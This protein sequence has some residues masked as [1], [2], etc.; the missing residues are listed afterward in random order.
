MQKY[1][2]WCNNNW[3]SSKF[4]YVNVKFENMKK[5]PL[6]QAN[7]GQIWL[8]LTEK[9]RQKFSFQPKLTENAHLQAHFDLLEH[10]LSFLI[11]NMGYWWIFRKIVFLNYSPPF[12]EICALCLVGLEKNFLPL[13]NETG[14]HLRRESS[15]IE[16]S[17]TLWIFATDSMS[18]SNF[19]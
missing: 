18:S 16:R 9:L 1:S 12:F 11:K 15:F 19:Y 17:R 3:K 14:C 6:K 4:W 8:F 7:F 2:F 13:F 5:N 10:V